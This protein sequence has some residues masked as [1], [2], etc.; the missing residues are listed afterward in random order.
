M[1]L[2]FVFGPLA[3][4]P[5]RVDGPPSGQL[6]G[7]RYARRGSYRTVHTIDEQRQ[8]VDVVRIDHR[9]DVYR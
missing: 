8:Q 2:A 5:L 7:M 9:G 1:I 4:E 3:R 6:T